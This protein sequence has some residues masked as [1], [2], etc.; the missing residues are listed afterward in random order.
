[1]K[2]TTFALFLS[3]VLMF[4]LCACS[5]PTPTEYKVSGINFTITDDLVEETDP[6][7]V[8]Q[9]AV[10]MG[11]VDSTSEWEDMILDSKL[12]IGSEY[13]VF[14]TARLMGYNN[15]ELD[16]CI[17]NAFADTSSFLSESEPLSINPET[18]EVDGGELNIN[19]DYDPLSAVTYEDYKTVELDQLT[20]RIGAY[21][22]MGAQTH[23]LYALHDGIF[24]EIEVYPYKE[25]GYPENYLEDIAKTISFD[26][27]LIKYKKTTLGELTFKVPE[28]YVDL[29]Y[30]E[31]DAIDAV[32]YG[33]FGDDYAEMSAICINKNDWNYSSI[34][35]IADNFLSSNDLYNS[36]RESSEIQISVNDSTTTATCEYSIGVSDD[37]GN[38]IS[39]V[40]DYNGKTYWFEIHGVENAEPEYLSS[41]VNSAEIN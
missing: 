36:S 13:D 41:I 10:D 16:E 25:N 26:N 37:Y 31:P 29:K 32:A 7:T 12:L 34:N 38:Q 39:A 28:N 33:L 19:E 4:L 3:A 22:I 9:Y 14:I 24:Y 40:F 21:E 5:E 15:S 17:E 1:M 2:K 18:E 8:S 27:S 6:T 35:E 20:C 23:Y 30:D 11:I